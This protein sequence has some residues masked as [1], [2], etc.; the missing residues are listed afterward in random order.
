MIWFENI[1]RSLVHFKEFLMI[2]FPAIKLCQRR[3]FFFKHVVWWSVFCALC[4]C[5]CGLLQVGDRLLSI[6]GIPTEDGTLEEAHQLL[7][8]SA[9]ANK[10]AV[11]VEFD[12]AG[13]TLFKWFLSV[14]N[15]LS[16]ASF[17]VLISVH[18]KP[19][20]ESVVPSS[21]TFHV[22]LP[23]R[24]GVDL[25][26]IISGELCSAK[27]E[28]QGAVLLTKNSRDPARSTSEPVFCDP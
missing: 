20:P 4:L 16:L 12:V 15:C 10:V 1:S 21:G 24:R 11:E 23:K 25:G 19:S 13:T 22:K 14:Q 18:S 28:H 17:L 9:L 8:D 27:D 5:R 26:I 3:F 2:S 6:N 7:R